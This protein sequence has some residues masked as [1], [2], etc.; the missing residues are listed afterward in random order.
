MTFHTVRPYRW[1][2][3]PFVIITLI[4]LVSTSTDGAHTPHD[5][6]HIDG[7][8]NLTAT[9]GVSSGSG[10]PE[11]PYIIEDL[12]ITGP[13]FRAIYVKN[14][15][16]HLVI[17]NIKVR[18]DTGVDSGITLSSV[19]N[20]TIHDCELL[21]TFSTVVFHYSSAIRVFNVTSSPGYIVVRNSDGVILDNVTVN[22][23]SIGVYIED[24]TNCSITRCHISNISARGMHILGTNR[25][26]TIAD[27]VLENARLWG[28]SIYT[29]DMASDDIYIINNRI[30]SCYRSIE[31][32]GYKRVQIEGNTVE[33]DDV[34]GI[35]VTRYNWLRF[36]DND[37]EYSGVALDVTDLDNDSI[38][39]ENNTVRGKPIWLLRNA[40]D[41]VIDEDL[42]QLILY[43]CK[44]IDVHGLSIDRV[45]TPVYIYLCDDVS[46]SGCDLASNRYSISVTSS[47]NVS[48]QGCNISDSFRAI[49]ASRVVSMSINDCVLVN[50]TA[51]TSLASV[52]PLQ[53]TG[54]SFTGGLSGISIGIEA[55]EPMA[56]DITVSNNVFEGGYTGIFMSYVIASNITGNEIT[57]CER[58]GID[59]T[60]MVSTIVTDNTVS[61]C[62][63]SGI[64]VSYGEGDTIE[65]NILRD[66][67]NGISAIS[68]MR[69]TIGRKVIE[70]CRERGILLDQCDN[71]TVFGNLLRDCSAF[72][73]E[74]LECTS[75]GVY[76]NNLVSIGPVNVSDDDGT[77]N[78]WDDVV[79]GNYWSDYRARYPSATAN[80][81]VW[82]TPYSIPGNT[83][84]FDMFPLAEQVDWLPPIADAGED[85]TIEEGQKAS[86]DGSGSFD[87]VGIVSY[88]WTFTYNGSVIDLPGTSASFLFS[89]P[90]TY[91]VD[92]TVKDRAGNVVVGALL[93]T[94][95]DVLDP[96]ADAGMDRS[97]EVM[98]PVE[99]DGSASRDTGGIAVYNWT[100]VHGEQVIHLEGDTVTHTFDALG[101]Y[102]I[103]LRVVDDVGRFDEDTVTITAIDSVG[104]HPAILAPDVVDQG[105][106]VQLDGSTSYDNLNI[107][108]FRWTFE[109]EGAPMLLEGPEVEYTFE[110]A[111]EYVIALTVMDTSGNEGSA[112]HSLMVMDITPPSANPG[113][114]RSTPQ[115][116]EYVLRDFGSTDDTGVVGN[117]WSFEVGGEDVLLDGEDVTYTF[118]IPGKYVIMLTVADAA[119][120]TDDATFTLTVID[121]E[122]PTVAVLDDISAEAGETVTFNASGSTDNVG[123]MSYSWEFTYD[124][125]ATVLE[126][127]S[128]EFTFKR[129]GEY[130]VTLTLIDAAGNVDMDSF[131]VSVRKEDGT[132]GGS[133]I[134]VVIASVII[135]VV[136]SLSFVLFRRR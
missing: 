134:W 82:D 113:S 87:D 73:V 11:D 17:R 61:G 4:A 19:S 60:H 5:S 55:G 110:V 24:V 21:G 62:N 6:I 40:T 41:L 120:N 35:H 33:D 31:V 52:T 36:K 121:T 7:N 65:L 107:T 29:R 93:V 136:A 98:V 8:A 23:A 3:L 67:T 90:G 130:P 127:A 9:N 69:L 100:I 38:D 48:I 27:N 77:F 80:D 37:V 39:F 1:L 116:Q 2:F 79:R 46:I 129:G 135:V 94:V 118:H 119:G 102:Q 26:L 20:C 56:E 64:E 18:N 81:R 15:D 12:L 112:T 103:T 133:Y 30:S 124:G 114:D 71:T 104:P 99:L 54:N 128:T 109:Y 75:T 44:G 58:N 78:R 105:A 49:L 42:G 131:T 123:I 70:R 95:L 101:E 22:G 88:N 47:S 84:S 126:G 14:T 125:E 16:A 92:L 108:S 68:T 34:I 86:F 25:N 96:V 106:V 89:I 32:D 43:G 10:T 91:T 117:T 115:D 72:H 76:H 53:V 51:G 45:W 111:G 63:D 74:L 97:V 57:G 83:G 13:N 66:N 132:D 122:R 28:L 85:I 59:L 50:C